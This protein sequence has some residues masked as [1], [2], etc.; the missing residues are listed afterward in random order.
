LATTAERKTTGRHE[1]PQRSFLLELPGLLL[2]ALLV[3]VA[4]RMAVLA[5]RH[6]LHET[7]VGR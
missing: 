3:A 5:Y 4:F 6:P 1:K 2:A 7:P